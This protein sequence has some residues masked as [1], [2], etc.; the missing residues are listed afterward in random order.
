MKITWAYLRR[1]FH[2]LWGTLRLRDHRMITMWIDKRTTLITCACGKV[3][4]VSPDGKDLLTMNVFIVK[5]MT[6]SYTENK[7]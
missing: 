6:E 5:A 1:Y 3:F 7:T 2:Y 4:Y